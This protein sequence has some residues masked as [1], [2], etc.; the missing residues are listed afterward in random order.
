MAGSTV[1]RKR[2]VKR[3]QIIDAARTVLARNGLAACTARAVADASPLT[4]SAIHYYFRDID[5]TVDR[6]VLAHLDAMLATLRQRATAIAAPAAG[7]AAVV[8]A[9]LDT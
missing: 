5:E 4:K 2:D 7:P 6:A 8:T 9:C 1:A 3:E